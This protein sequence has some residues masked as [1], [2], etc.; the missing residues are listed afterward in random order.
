MTEFWFFDNQQI[1]HLYLLDWFHKSY[2]K[3]HI[4][5]LIKADNE[6]ISNEL[7]KLQA[8]VESDYVNK[9][10]YDELNS[11]CFALLDILKKEGLLEKY[12]ITINPK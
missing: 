1:Y 3:I 11:K 10:T 9:S 6:K 5:F 7:S 4:Y 12:N 8:A 2:S